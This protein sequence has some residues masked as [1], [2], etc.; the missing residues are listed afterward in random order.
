M[1]KT[2]IAL[3]ILCALP[4]L[5]QS[6]DMA[7]MH[8]LAAFTHANYDTNPMPFAAFVVDTRSG[9]I[10]SRALNRVGADADPT[11]HAEVAAIRATRRISLTGCT[12][13]TTCEPCPMCAAACMWANLDRVVY[14][15]TISDVSPLIRQIHVP[16]REIASHADWKCA[17]VG[18]VDRTECVALFED[19]R[20][21]K[22]LAR[23]RKH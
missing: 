10:I 1:L 8:E 18:P 20:A 4:C 13:Y 3:I 6:R 7:V 14:G 2:L 16:A 15:A 11:M 17:F 5:A 21:R 12:L 9:K 22:V 19:P 23:W